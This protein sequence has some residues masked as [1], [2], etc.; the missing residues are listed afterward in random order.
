MTLLIPLGLLG[1]LAIA[2]L[3]LIYIIKPNYQQKFIS[4]TYVWKLSLKLKR[5]KLPLNRLRNILLLLCQILFLASCAMALS[6]PV[7][8]TNAEISSRDVVAIIDSSAS[9]RAGENGDTR[10]NRAVESVKNLADEVYGQGG[11]MTV[12]VAGEECSLIVQ[13]SQAASRATL[14]QGLDKLLSTDDGG[15]SYGTADIDA[16]MVLCEEIVGD[17]SEA[18]IYLYTDTEYAYKPANVEVINV[19]AEDEWNAAI[20]D[21][22]TVVQDNYYV[23]YV[24]VACYGVNEIVSLDIQVNGRNGN[25][26]D[27][28]NIRTEVACSNDQVMTVILRDSNQP[29][30][31]YEQTASN[32]SVILLEHDTQAFYSYQDIQIVLSTSGGIPDSFSYDNSFAIYDG[33]RE[34]I[35]VLYASSLPNPFVPTMIRAVGNEYANSNIWNISLTQVPVTGNIPSQYLSNY[36][37]YIFEHVMPD[38]MPVDGVVMLWDV[39][40]APNG[41]G[42]TVSPSEIDYSSTGQIYLVQESDNPILNN[43]TVGNISVTKFRPFESITDDHYEV[44]AS[45]DGYPVIIAKNSGDQRVIALN[46]SIHYS[47]FALDFIGL[48]AFFYNIFENYIPYTVAGN[49]FEVYEN[50]LVNSRGESLTVT[51]GGVQ[52]GEPIKDLPK[53]IVL[54]TPG[55]YTLSQRTAFGE[56]ISKNIYVTIPSYEC[57]IWQHEDTFRAPYLEGLGEESYNDLLVYIASAMAA[58]IFIEWLLHSRENI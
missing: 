13:R 8:M 6:Q 23:L 24:Q 2:A 1:L 35:N 54:T 10:I 57:N 40:E 16:A 52:V 53:T 50:I 48:T 7:I 5:K 14:E 43:V 39:D 47:N 9:M 51:R 37:L 17:N 18:E 44:L 25:A 34:T 31:D 49:A 21:A 27:T 15:C 32:I 30:Q 36:D 12:I 20:L 55:T 3:I 29:A 41:A 46:F 58:L 22:Y 56:D 4:S 42:F 26:G 38:Y 33:D 28:L 45:A 11:L 19:S